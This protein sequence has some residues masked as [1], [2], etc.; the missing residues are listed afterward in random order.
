MSSKNALLLS[1]LVGRAD[2]M[3]VICDRCGRHGRLSVARLARKNA[4]ETSLAAMMRA[5]I[6]D[7][8]NRNAQQERERCDP[9]SPTL[10]QLFAGPAG[11]DVN[12]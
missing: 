10:G 2:I 1:D 4:H 8:P 9:Y 5:Q 11:G 12:A 3:E 6:G 7:C